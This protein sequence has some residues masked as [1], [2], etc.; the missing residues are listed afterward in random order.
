MS[1]KKC[2]TTV[3]M[4]VMLCVFALLPSTFTAKAEGADLTEF[5]TT[6]SNGHATV[7]A[8]MNAGGIYTT[9]NVDGLLTDSSSAVISAEYLKNSVTK[10]E[11]DGKYRNAHTDVLKVCKNSHVFK[12]ENGY[13]PDIY[14]PSDGGIVLVHNKVYEFSTKIASATTYSEIAG[15]YSDWLTF[16]GSNE[17]S[18]KINELSSKGEFSVKVSSDQLIFAEDDE[19]AVSKF[20]DTVIIKN[21]AQAISDSEE[22]LNEDSGIAY[23]ISIKWIRNGVVMEGESVP[24][25]AVTV[26]INLEDINL[27]SAED[28]QLARYLGQGK[29]EFIETTVSDGNLVFTLDSFGTDIESDFSLDFAIV[30]KGYQKKTSPIL[31][32]VIVGVS[33]LL[34]VFI[35]FQIVFAVKKRR[36]K[37]SYKSFVKQLKSERKNKTNDIEE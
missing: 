15:A 31:T 35:V 30:A 8:F 29:V 18:L 1:L 36:R 22:L 10:E 25:S 13:D 16:I 26:S 28:I 33:V 9:E 12:I 20:L 11:Y 14:S 7:V 4:A 21:T 5:E 2:F 32:Y 27:S 6:L 19:L 17:P 37:K 34:V 23:F 3:I 24:D